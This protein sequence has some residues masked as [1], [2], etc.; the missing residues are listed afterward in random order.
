MLCRIDSGMLLHLLLCVVVLLRLLLRPTGAPPP[1]P[2][3]LTLLDLIPPPTVFVQQ[4]TSKSKQIS[5]DKNVYLE[6]DVK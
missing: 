3:H 6:T 2:L 4:P 5:R 1:P